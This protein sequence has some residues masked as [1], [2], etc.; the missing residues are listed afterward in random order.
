MEALTSAEFALTLDT[1]VLAEQQAGGEAALRTMTRID[2][3]RLLRGLSTG[4][5]SVYVSS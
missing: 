5:A 3:D 4:L 2:Y 1:S